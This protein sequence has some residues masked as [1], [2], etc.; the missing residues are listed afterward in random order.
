MTAPQLP[1][2][3]CLADRI[4][5]AHETLAWLG[6]TIQG[7]AFDELLADRVRACL[8]QVAGSASGRCSVA[9]LS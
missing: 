2:A 5:H 1:A 6:S 3:M 9:W 7:L 4:V 8:Q